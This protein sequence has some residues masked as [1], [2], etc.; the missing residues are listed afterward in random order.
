MFDNIWNTIGFG[1]P[2]TLYQ[3]LG[4]GVWCLVIA[5][6]WFAFG[7]SGTFI[8]WLFVVSLGFMAGGWIAKMVWT[9]Q[10]ML[11]EESASNT[12]S[13]QVEEEL[14]LDPERDY[15]VNPGE[16]IWITV[17]NSSIRIVQRDGGIAQ[18]QAYPLYREDEDPISELEV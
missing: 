12:R 4:R 14:I 5:A 9:V 1:T 11:A 2:V 18:V 10:Q 16:P 8:G 7:Y 15:V 6:L 13:P 17:G 3:M